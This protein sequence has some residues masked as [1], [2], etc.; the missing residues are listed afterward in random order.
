MSAATASSIGADDGQPVTVSSEAGELTLPLVVTEMA[1]GV[2]WLPTNQ[3]G[4][5]VR[6]ELGVD[7]GATVTIAAATSGGAA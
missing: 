2:V 3:T 6:A 4:Y 7:S 1:D 5:P